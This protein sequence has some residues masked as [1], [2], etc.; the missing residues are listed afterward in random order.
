MPTILSPEELKAR[1]S[2]TKKSV[3]WND[4][5]LL[6]H[7]LKVHAEGE[8]PIHLIKA[9]RPNES[10]AVRTYRQSIYEAETQNPIQRVISV[11]EKIRRS[12]DWMIRFRDD[13]PAMITKEE[14]LE[15]YIDGKYPVYKTLENW[16]FEEALKAI[17]LDANGVCIVMPQDLNVNGM[18]YIK[19]VAMIFNA[20]QIVDFVTDDYVIVRSDEYSSKLST[21]VQQTR[22]QAIAGFTGNPFLD[23]S[24][25]NRVDLPYSTSAMVFYVVD[26]YSY[27]K[28][29]EVDGGMYMLTQQYVHGLNSLPAFQL[30]GKFHKRMGS[31]VIKTTPLNPMVPHLN[32]AARESNDLDIGVVKHLHPQ[33]WRINNI[34]C[35]E[36]SGTGKTLVSGSTT[37]CKACKGEGVS[38]GSSPVDEIIIKPAAIGEQNIP[39]PAM[40]YVEMNVEIIKIQN[41][42]IE[43]HLYK[44]LAAVNMD[45]LS[46]TPLNIS[47]KG[48]EL[49]RDEMNSVIS[50]FAESLVFVADHVCKWVN[51]LR[52]KGV[53]ADEVKRNDMRPIIPVPEKFDIINTTFLITEY[54]TAKTAGLSS[55]ILAE[56]E[57]EIAQKKFYSND[58]VSGFV[59]TVMDCNPLLG[60][61]IEEK[62]LLSGSGLVTKEDAIMSVYITD[63]VNR[64]LE[65]DK[66]FLDK[67]K[68]DKRKILLQYATE[69]AALLN[70][71]A[72]MA[73]DIFEGGAPAKKEPADKEEGVAA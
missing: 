52:Y 73:Q 22:A 27:Q 34:Q 6:Y 13:I 16:L 8:M 49:D 50:W 42:R 28:W 26:N 2:G 71:A 21:D 11:L 64:A 20:P 51:E 59:Q 70:T 48:K 66:N 63:F 32:K 25:S 56:L 45:H 44:A 58:E 30:P 1:F 31:S 38:N 53:V 33:K 12:P 47:G 37:Q 4:S 29:E 69:K 24:S 18:E 23:A 54:S 7:K 72:T 9:A 5:V 36:C 68:V 3:A 17:A 35:G 67:S 19:P 57:K 55:T 60:L 41:E 39:V 14:T 10:E 46:S 62:S 43:E 40:G 15:S 61:S 65:E